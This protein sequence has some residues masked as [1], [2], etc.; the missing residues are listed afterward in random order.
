MSDQ[1]PITFEFIKKQFKENWEANTTWGKSSTVGIAAV[2]CLA[3]AGQLAPNPYAMAGGCI[4]GGG[5]MAVGGVMASQKYFPKVTPEHG[6]P[7]ATQK[8]TVLQK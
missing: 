4:V 3:G 1:N 5:I 8:S 7:A 2:G 6:L